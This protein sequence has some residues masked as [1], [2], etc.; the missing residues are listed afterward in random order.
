MAFSF[1]LRRH[2]CLKR[3]AKRIPLAWKPAVPQRPRV[4]IADD[5]PDV[6]KVLMWILD[7]HCEVVATAAD[8]EA[9]LQ[10][11][12]VWM[13]D[14]VVTDIAMPHMN[15]LEA[16]RHLRRLYP[17]ISVILVTALPDKD[18]LAQGMQLGATAVVHK[19]NMAV[20]LPAAVLKP[21]A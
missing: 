1:A 4:I 9:L 15:G 21:V 13:P 11:V 5:H 2:S 3:D 20:D 14:I 7:P 19:R 18:V 16:C 17:F 8:G 6:L 10:Q 12:R